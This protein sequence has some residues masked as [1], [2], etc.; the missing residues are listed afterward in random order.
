MQKKVSLKILTFLIILICVTIPSKAFAVD[1]CYQGSVL[2]GKP[3]LGGKLIGVFYQLR[4]YGYGDKNNSEEWLNSTKPN[5]SPRWWSEY[6]FK[7]Y[8][9]RNKLKLENKLWNDEYNAGLVRDKDEDKK[10]GIIFYNGAVCFGHQDKL[11]GETST[12]KVYTFDINY[13][14]EISTFG[15]HK[16]ILQK[17]AYEAYQSRIRNEIGALGLKRNYNKACIAQMAVQL[18]NWSDAIPNINSTEAYVSYINAKG[19]NKEEREKLYHD[20]DVASGAYA[21]AITEETFERG[22]GDEPNISVSGNHTFIGP[23]NINNK[24]GNLTKA[25]ITMD[26]GTTITTTKYS[27]DGNTV[28]GNIADIKDYSDELYIVLDNTDIGNISNIVLHKQ[29]IY[30]KARCVLGVPDTGSTG[31]QDICLYYAVKKTREKT[32]NLLKPQGNGDLQIVKED[33]NLNKLGGVTFIVQV[34]DGNGNFV[35][36]KDKGNGLYEVTDYVSTEYAN[37]NVMFTTPEDGTNKGKITITGLKTG[38]YRITEIYNSNIGYKQNSAIERTKRKDKEGKVLE[39]LYWTVNV[40][41]GKTAIPTSYDSN[42]GL[43]NKSYGNLK[44]IKTGNSGDSTI[45]KDV[46]F[47]IKDLATGYYLEATEKTGE[48]GA[49]NCIGDYLK[50]SEAT[51]FKTNEN[52]EIKIYDLNA[53]REYQIIE[54]KNPNNGYSENAGITKNITVLSETSTEQFTELNFANKGTGALKIVKVDEDT[55]EKLGQGVE[56]ILQKKDNNKG[57]VQADNNYKVTGYGTQEKAK[58]FVTNANSEIIIGNL[59]LGTYIVKETKNNKPG[60]SKNVGSTREVTVTLGEVTRP[61]TLNYTNIAYGNL[62]IIKQDITTKKKLSNVGFKIKHDTLGWVV[63]ASNGEISYTSVENSA[64]EFIT[65]KDGEIQVNDL[66]IGSYIIKET[67][68]LNFGY[69]ITSKEISAGIISPGQTTDKTVD[70]ERVYVKVSGYVWEDIKYYIGKDGYQNDLWRENKEDK[71]DKRLENVK[72]TLNYGKGKTK[73]ATTNEKGEYAFGNYTPGDSSTYKEKLKIEDLINAYIEFEYNGMCYT[74]VLVKHVENGSKA[75][76]TQNGK[77]REDF[78]NKYT[79][80]ENNKA[81]DTNNKETTLEYSY[82][83]HTSTLKYNKNA[84]EY[85]YGYKGQKYPISGV[86]DKFLITAITSDNYNKNSIF[87]Y[88]AENIKA[89]SIEEITNINLGLKEREMPDLAIIEDM[90]KAEVS[91]NNYTHTYYYEQRPSDITNTDNQKDES[92]FNVAVKFGSKY[93]TQSYKRTIYSSDISYNKQSENRGKLEVYITYKVAIRNESTSVYTKVN[94]LVNYFD[95]RYAINSIYYYTQDGKLEKKIEYKEDENY[96]KDGFKKVTL[97]VNQNI[98]PQSK[99][100]IYIQYKLDNDAINAVLN[101][102]ATLNSV[103]EISSYSTYEDKNFS[104]VYGGIESDSNPETAKPINKETYEDDTDSAPSLILEL[105]EGRVIKGTVWEDSAI[106]EELEKSGYE[107]QRIGNGK[108]DSNTENVVGNVTVELLS[109]DDGNKIAKL[110]KKDKSVLDAKTT[111]DQKGNYEF[112][113]VI[114]GKYV[115]RYTYG[116]KSVIYD[117]SGKE[118]QNVKADNYKS[119]IY[120]GDVQELYWYR[121]ET[122]N[123]A[124]RLSDARDRVGIKK[125][126]SEIDIVKERTTKSDEEI[127]YKNASEESLTEIKAETNNFDIKLDYD[128]NL[129]NISQYETDL[130][131]VFDNIDFGIIRRPQQK[132]DLKKEISYVEL[133]LANGQTVISGDPRVDNI[134]NLRQLPQDENG[135]WG[136]VAIEL[137]QEIIQ[138]STL[139]VTYEITADNTGTEID[140]NDK[141]YYLYGIVPN[142]KQSNAKIARVSR[143]YD[144]IENDINVDPNQE[145][146]REINKQEELKKGQNMSTESYNVFSQYNKILET[147]KLSDMKP[148]EPKKVSI[149][150]SRLLANTTDEVSV[151]NIVEVNALKEGRVDNSIPGNYDPTNSRETHEPD[152]DSTGVD[153]TGPTG[154]GKNYTPYILLTISSLLILAAGILIIKTKVTK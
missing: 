77:N 71:E 38:E 144:Y 36:A 98:E 87:N 142:D 115:I 51:V 152:D 113:G 62:K 106:A 127:I 126:S 145:G 99:K 116:N 33:G 25:V 151:N 118:I 139:K 90:E 7:E 148:G 130:K 6:G 27:T 134:K 37:N 39:P 63:R 128:V 40:E 52:A 61:V 143:L 68:N 43:T 95:N 72:V 46:E 136:N 9:V 4:Y 103:T 120:R 2:Q 16:Y 26:N 13:N 18:C 149:V 154:K 48:S 93:G 32:L 23:Y 17:F 96:N 94:K 24:Y 31:D 117:T 60:Y 150:I 66:R 80:I 131:F 30:Y 100:D 141:D 135:H 47:K 92:G 147:T 54:I 129:D 86:D 122:G 137:D 14:N 12:V 85:K 133:I 104:K 35:M 138:G 22:I 57:F 114:P 102:R 109:I 49:Y 84:S 112:S 79:T 74:N 146:W 125:D 107:K 55:N 105:Q 83:N 97:N 41:A 65:N 42:T 101:K 140:Y 34:K 121:N 20:T 29:Y 64:T 5:G 88:T 78:N 73:I 123:G 110:Y 10:D 59:D 69:E 81:I 82:N 132:L 15:E 119:T 3:A 91:L 89:N 11:N 45:Q 124:P 75:T 1:F 153:I 76:E 111:T 67:K 53:Q 58:T 21:A 28:K 70:N 56:F 50:E 19:G 108:Y 8:G 44:I